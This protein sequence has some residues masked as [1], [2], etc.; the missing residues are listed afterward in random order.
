[1]AILDGSGRTGHHQV[2][3]I[4]A[5]D[6]FVARMNGPIPSFNYSPPSGKHF[7]ERSM[8]SFAKIILI[9]GAVMVGAAGVLADEDPVKA[10][11]ELMKTVVE[12]TKLSG[13]MVKGAI[14][15]EAAKAAAAMQSIADA[16]DKFG[17]LFPAS[18]NLGDTFPA[19]SK[20]GDTQ[21]APK[22][23]TDM[24]GFEDWNRKLKDTATA[25]VAAAGQS[26]AAFK[27]AFGAMVKT[28]KG[29]HES[30]RLKKQ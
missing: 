16:P 21:S 25:G 18:S 29:C 28:C 24:K 22:I 4:R 17:R 20:A 9:A 27:M 10:R 8:N 13:G 7:W 26:E 3:K 15:F 30:Y 1:M 14:P 2:I 12:G 6:L 5:A 23:W 19:G 11:K